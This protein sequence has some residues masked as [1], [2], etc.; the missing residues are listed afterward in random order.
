MRN[1]VDQSAP[2][3]TQYDFEELLDR[4]EGYGI[5]DLH[6]RKERMG[7]YSL[8]GR[9]QALNGWSSKICGDGWTRISAALNLI[10]KVTAQ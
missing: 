10:E 2:E 8:D 3:I 6:L 1:Q 7:S 9:R 4:L 5:I